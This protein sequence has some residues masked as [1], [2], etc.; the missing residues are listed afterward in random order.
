MATLFAATASRLTALGGCTA[1]RCRSTRAQA[2]AAQPWGLR[3]RPGRSS[4]SRSKDGSRPTGL[5]FRQA[6]GD[7]NLFA[8]ATASRLTA[9]GGCTAGRGASSRSAGRRP[10]PHKPWGLRSRPGR[11]SSSRSKDGSRPT[12]PSAAPRGKDGSSSARSRK[13]ARSTWGLHS[14]PVHRQPEHRAQ[15]GRTSLGGFA[16]GRGAAALLAARMAAGQLAFSRSKRQGRQLFGAQASV[17][18][19][20]GA[21]ALGASQHFGRCAARGSRTALRAAKQIGPSDVGGGH[22][23]QSEEGHRRQ[24]KT[25]LHG[26][27]SL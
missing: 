12:W 9:L 20:A 16:A 22:D 24:Q 26:S 18:P 5:Q 21:Q 11:S 8:T 27:N 7:G 6:G 14:R 23:A 19:Q 25:T 15:A 1:G 17:Q 10:E 13:P 4:S 2:G 3:S